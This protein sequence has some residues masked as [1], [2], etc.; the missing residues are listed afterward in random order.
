[1]VLRIRRI[2]LFVHDIEAVARFYRDVVGLPLKNEE[3]PSWLEFDAGS[4]VL[5]LHNGGE[6]NKARRPPKVV[7]YADDVESARQELIRRGAK[8]GPFRSSTSLSLCDGKDPE[9]NTFQI[10]N[11][12]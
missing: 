10:S 8:M 6:P 12:P 7:F 11:R 4:C 2:I 3:R 9:G 5:A 1:M